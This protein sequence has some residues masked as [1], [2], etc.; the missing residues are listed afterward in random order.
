MNLGDESIAYLRRSRC[1]PESQDMPLEVHTGVVDCLRRLSGQVLP[2]TLPQLRDRR[3]FRTGAFLGCGIFAPVDPF[4]QFLGFL[5]GSRYRPVR[6]ASDGVPP[7]RAI[8]EVIQEE[9]AR[10]ARMP[11]RW[12]EYPQTEALD[13]IVI[14]QRRTLVRGRFRFHNV[15]GKLD[16]HDS[17]FVSL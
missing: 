2:V 17:P 3:R 9:C 4:A 15:L 5:T 16:W 7:L 11:I 8:A 14:D 6:V 10:A 1:R 12:R 13:L